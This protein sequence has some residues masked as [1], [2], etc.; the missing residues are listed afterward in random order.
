MPGPLGILAEQ[1]HAMNMVGHDHKRIELHLGKMLRDLFP[2]KHHRVSCRV[3]QHFPLHNITEKA[4]MGAAADGHEISV[5]LTVIVVGK[6]QPA[7]LRF[8]CSGDRRRKRE[9]IGTSYPRPVFL[10][11]LLAPESAVKRRP[12][13][14]PARPLRARGGG[15]RRWV[16][17]RRW[18]ARWRAGWEMRIC[19]GDSFSGGRR[20]DLIKR[21]LRGATRQERPALT[22]TGV[23]RSV[24]AI[25]GAGLILSMRQTGIPPVCV[26]SNHGVIESTE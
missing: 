26:K 2:A 19:G 13:A 4:S 14:G 17:I 20:M 18:C 9:H 25:R 3:A 6:P 11:N 16:L 1:Q 10:T 5:G 12:R 23:E 8:L 21:V 22:S 24:F 15:D 7:P